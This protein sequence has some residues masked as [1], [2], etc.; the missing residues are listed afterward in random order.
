MQQRYVSCVSC[1]SI[2]MWVWVSAFVCVCVCMCVCGCGCVCMG[3][4][5]GVRV[6]ARERE[7]ITNRKYNWLSFET[8]TLCYLDY[9]ILAVTSDGPINRHSKLPD[10]LWSSEQHVE[11]LLSDF[12]SWL[13]EIL[14]QLLSM[15]GPRHL[16]MVSW[17]LQTFDWPLLDLRG[18]KLMNSWSSNHNLTAGY[19]RKTLCFIPNDW[20]AN[21]GRGC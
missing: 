16:A 14:A 15:V 18:F 9:K 11:L 5:V 19:V 3:V 8:S 4:G 13:A 17:V 12:W 1:V 21:P 10:R 20:V 2:A 7:R 6:W